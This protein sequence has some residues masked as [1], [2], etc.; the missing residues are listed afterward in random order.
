[1]AEHRAYAIYGV[2]IIRSKWSDSDGNLSPLRLQ[3]VAAAGLE[4]L[5]TASYED[6]HALDRRL[7]IGCSL[8]GLFPR[9][10][11]AKMSATEA[12]LAALGTPGVPTL[13]ILMDVS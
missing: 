1:M 12:A 4:C 7:H 10:I 9:E 11:R 13:H 8:D 3:E 6:C 2:R 5:D